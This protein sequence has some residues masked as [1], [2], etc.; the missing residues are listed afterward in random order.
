MPKGESRLLCSYLCL[1]LAAFLHASR[2]A[3]ATI[4]VTGTGDTIA[5]DGV[6]TLREAMASINSGANVNA[7]VVP[8]GAYG[9]N[10][11][12]NFLIPGAGVKTIAPLIAL[13]TMTKTVLI[14]GYSQP[15]TAVNTLAQGTNAVL[16]IVVSGASF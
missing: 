5:V 10:D 6:V 2:V 14:N 8:V 3:G 12:I 1:A 9:T 11:T 16:K 15:G 4:T 7:D 13:P